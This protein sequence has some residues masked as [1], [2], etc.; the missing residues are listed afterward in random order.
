[1]ADNNPPPGVG[2]G[3]PRACL[4]SFI[5]VEFPQFQFLFIGRFTS[6]SNM[7]ASAAVPRPPRGGDA[8]KVADFPK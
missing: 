5:S 2:P 3:Y 4:V 1:M 7:A 8:P 6:A